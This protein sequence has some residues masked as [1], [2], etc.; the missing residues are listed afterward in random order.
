L[1]EDVDD[2]HR[3]VPPRQC[4]VVQHLEL[5]RYIGIENA[6]ARPHD[7]LIRQV[8]V[9]VTIKL[10][11]GCFDGGSGNSSP[12]GKNC[13]RTQIEWDGE[14]RAFQ[15]KVSGR[16]HREARPI[17]D[18]ALGARKL[19]KCLHD[20][21]LEGANIYKIRARLQRGGIFE[22]THC[23]VILDDGVHV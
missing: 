1:A 21:F 7:V 15:K 14:S 6:E 4:G 9:L 18:G 23:F 12:I 13:H 19:R 5:C 11:L 8:V 10:R 3:R 2:G 16:V 17:M 20:V 22:E